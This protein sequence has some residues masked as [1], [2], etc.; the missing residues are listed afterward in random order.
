[1]G[2]PIIFSGNDAKLLKPN[3]DF[4][5]NAKILSG[6]VDPTSVATSAPKG[7]LYL[8]TS[9]GFTYR[10][11]DA[12]STTNW[13]ILA[14][15]SS[16]PGDIS[17]TSFSAANNQSSPTNV[18]GLAFANATVRSF[19][20]LVSVFVDA[21]ADLFEQFSLYGIQ[22]GASWEMSAT[23][24]GDASGFTFSITNAGQVQYTNSNYAGF[25][26]AVVKFRAITTSV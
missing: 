19:D 4:F 1:M 20:A 9:T 18:T 24:T 5:G 21:T 23:G 2:A 17:E 6:S 7:S 3:L 22:K 8:N 15:Q 16:S 14:A 25:S 11:T 13:V 12:G 10:K 26:S